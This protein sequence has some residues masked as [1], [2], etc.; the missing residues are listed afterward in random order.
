MCLNETYGK[1][2]VGKKSDAVVM[3]DGMEQGNAVSSLLF[4]FAFEIPKGLQME[5]IISWPMLM[6]FMFS[7]N[8]NIRRN[9]ELLEDS[10][11][12]GLDVNTEK[13]KYMIVFRHQNAE[14]NYNLLTDN[15]SFQM[16]QSSSI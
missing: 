7:E 10:R 2:R 8:T 14:Q 13:T 12:F 9:R 15:K 4:N 11:E 1:V 3:Q 16:W 5:H 6:M